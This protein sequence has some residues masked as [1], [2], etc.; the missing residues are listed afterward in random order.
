M[1]F[2]PPGF[3]SPDFDCSDD[4]GEWWSRAF[5]TSFSGNGDEDDGEGIDQEEEEERFTK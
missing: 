5:L 2:Q 1:D 4:G 3:R